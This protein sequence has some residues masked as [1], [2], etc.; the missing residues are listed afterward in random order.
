MTVLEAAGN[1]IGGAPS[2]G[3]TSAPAA[4]CESLKSLCE[5]IR[6]CRYCR[7]ATPNAKLPHE[8]RPI[9]QLSA[10]A[11]LFVC[12]QAPGI[13]AHNSGT[14]FMDP[15]GVRLRAWMGVSEEEF[16][17]AA[18]VAIVPMG[19]CFPGYDANGGDLPPRPEC[20]RLWRRRVFEALPQT[21]SLILLVGGYSQRWHLGEAAKG[22]LTDTL[23]QWRSIL[24]APLGTTALLPLPHPSWRNNGWLKR[25]PWFEADVLP[26]LRARVR[27][28]LS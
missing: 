9:F 7:D 12:S 19:F 11:R 16:Y 5:T 28:T 27:E 17:D 10:T 8:P 18:K 21:P 24:D 25:N 4:A 6:A 23:K 26:V 20:E 14:P 3:D 1:A 13:R 22:T 2:A 15:S